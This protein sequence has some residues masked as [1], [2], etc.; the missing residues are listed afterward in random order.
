MKHQDI[1]ESYTDFERMILEDMEKQGYNIPPNTRQIQE[2]WKN[3]LEGAYMT[4]IHVEVFTKPDCP[5]CGAAKTMMNTYGVS[6]EEK[7]L[8]VHFTRE[9]LREKYPSAVTYPVIVVDGFFVGGYNQLKTLLEQ[10]LTGSSQL[11]NEGKNNY[12]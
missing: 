2:F 8:D 11:L 1:L 12:V 5:Y 7:I 6:Y 10:K 9:I 3:R 4:P